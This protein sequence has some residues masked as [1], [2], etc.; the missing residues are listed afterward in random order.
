[1]KFLVSKLINVLQQTKTE[2]AGR[3]ERPTIVHVSG[4]ETEVIFAEF[5]NRIRVDLLSSS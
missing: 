2:A 5:V 3:H 1:M 4:S